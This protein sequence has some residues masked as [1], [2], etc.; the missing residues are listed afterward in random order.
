[1]LQYN[2]VTLGRN[3]DRQL[4]KEPGGK[5]ISQLCLRPLFDRPLYD[6]FEVLAMGMNSHKHL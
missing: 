6:E 2:S 3:T 5:Y 4:L 1:M